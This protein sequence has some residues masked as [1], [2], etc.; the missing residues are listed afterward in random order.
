MCVL[1]KHDIETDNDKYFF[2]PLIPTSRIS[3]VKDIREWQLLT[4]EAV[5]TLCTVCVQPEEQTF[6]KKYLGNRL[7]KSH[8]L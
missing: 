6:R 2:G 4:I 5:E 3:S 7:S 8:M 1:F